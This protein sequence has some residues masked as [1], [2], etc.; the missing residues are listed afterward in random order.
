MTARLVRDRTPAPISGRLRKPPITTHDEER[1]RQP[2]WPESEPLRPSP[3][4]VARTTSGS[5]EG[6]HAAAYPEGTTPLGHR[7]GAT[8]IPL[9][10]SRLWWFVRLQRSGVFHHPTLPELSCGSARRRQPLE[11]LGRRVRSRLPCV[12]VRVVRRHAHFRRIRPNPRSA[13]LGLDESA[14][15]DP[16]GHHRDEESAS[17]AGRLLSG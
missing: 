13:D 17:S 5:C 8:H 1:S 15:R 14:A 16:S 10:G 2:R 9:L 3:R 11:L 6:P 7:A 4:R 12:V